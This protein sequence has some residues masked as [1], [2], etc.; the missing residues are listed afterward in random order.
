VAQSLQRGMG[1]AWVMLAIS[2][3]LSVTAFYL[4]KSSSQQAVQ[5]Q[6]EFRETEITEAIQQRM[7]AYT[8][9]LQGGLGL[10]KASDTVSR[11]EWK[12]YVATLSLDRLFPGIQGLGYSEWVTPEQRASYEAAIQ[13][14]GFPN[15]KIRPAGQRSLY[16]SITYLE[17]FDE[18]NRQAFG[19]DMYSNEMRRRA[20]DLARDTGRVAISGRVRLV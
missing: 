3:L 20:M 14:Q 4:V 1:W 11:E 15:F 10:F 2:L 5:N 18:R 8:Q 16:T 17:P 19:Y 7:A 13:A 12:V 6:F 9:A